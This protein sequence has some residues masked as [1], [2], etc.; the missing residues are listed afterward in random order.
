VGQVKGENKKMSV[1]TGKR[2]TSE[3]EFLN[4]AKKI[5]EA[6]CRMCR[7]M[8]KAMTFLKSQ[9]LAHMAMD[10][11]YNVLSANSIYPT[12]Q[13]EAQMRRDAFIN[14]ACKYKFLIAQMEVIHDISG[15]GTDKM[16]EM[17]A[18]IYKELEL[19]K[20]IIKKDKARYKN[21]P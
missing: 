15:I 21:L 10:A 11:F 4:T 17:S 7:K 6:T 12:N 20:A 14:A 1:P 3:M 18:L 16:L 9:R 13:H 2:G 8:P 19:L 5:D